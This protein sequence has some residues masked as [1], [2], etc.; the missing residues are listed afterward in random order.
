MAV[1]NVVNLTTAINLL[2]VVRVYALLMAVVVDVQ[3][4]AVTSQRSL[5]QSSV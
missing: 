5:L 2:L 3:W 4:M 1:V